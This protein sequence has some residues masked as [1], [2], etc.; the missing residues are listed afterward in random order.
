M[1]C[2]ILAIGRDLPCIKGVGGIKAIILCDYGTLGTLSVTGAEVT[3]I[4]TTPAGYQY[5]VKPGSSGMEETVTASAENGTIFY[6]QN[7]NIQ[8][9]KFFMSSAAVAKIAVA[10]SPIQP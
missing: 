1:A 8:L 4:S 10:S 9:Q 6:V 5:L 2:S 7:I 3:D